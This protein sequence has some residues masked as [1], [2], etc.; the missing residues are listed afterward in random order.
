M[1]EAWTC[2]QCGTVNE[3]SFVVCHQCGQVRPDLDRAAVA[4]VAGQP[5]VAEPAVTTS[6]AVDDTP[7]VAEAPV[8]PIAPPPSTP[9]SAAAAVAAGRIPGWTPPA[10]WSTPT[11]PGGFPAGPSEGWASTQGP[12][13][14]GAGPV[15]ATGW[16]T[17]NTTSPDGAAPAQGSGPDAPRTVPGWTTTPPAQRSLLRRIPIGW[18]VVIV[19]VAG[20]ALVGWYVNAARSSTGEINKAGDM[21]AT[22]LRV[23]DC[24]DLKNPSVDTVEDVRAVPCTTQHTYELFYRGDM[25]DGTYPND[26]AFDSWTTAN[27][28]PAFAT[29]V[30][31]SYDQSSLE[32]YYLVPTSDA[33]A[34]GDRSVQCALFPSNNAHPT[35][36][37]RGS[38]Q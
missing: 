6:Q 27:C 21:N 11:T 35:T 23:G 18:L 26:A 17:P 8:P 19:L 5:W 33:W 9:E 32:V 36:S 25:P 28:D 30:G 15:A 38:Q 22:D 20:G 24:F 7:P 13:Q 16:V 1:A 34:S 3:P 12:P 31:R 4:D 29:Y 37:L 10:E 2:S 14:P